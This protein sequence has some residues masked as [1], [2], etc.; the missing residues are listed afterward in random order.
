MNLFHFWLASFLKHRLVSLTTTFRAMTAALLEWILYVGCQKCAYKRSKYAKNLR[1]T[2]CPAEKRGQIFLAYL[3][4]FS[5]KCLLV[6]LTT[7]PDRAM[8]P[9]RLGIAIR[10]FRVSAISQAR[11]R[12]MVAPTKITMM[13]MI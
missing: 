9:I 12:S 11:P 1:G 3:L 7:T 4:A 8:T 5:E 13:K 10:P 2:M 6:S